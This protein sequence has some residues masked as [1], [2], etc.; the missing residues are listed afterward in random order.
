M[1]PDLI[2]VDL[3]PIYGE[4]EELARGVTDANKKIDNLTNMVK[5]LTKRVAELEAS[6]SAGHANGDAPKGLAAYDKFRTKVLDSA[7]K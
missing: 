1:H 2:M 4:L 3:H 6:A 7:P 5:Q